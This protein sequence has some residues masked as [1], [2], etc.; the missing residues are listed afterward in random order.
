MRVLE[1]L[2]FVPED[3]SPYPGVRGFRLTR[4]A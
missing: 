2:G 3:G 4:R 1:K